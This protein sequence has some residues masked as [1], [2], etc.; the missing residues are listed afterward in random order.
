MQINLRFKQDNSSLILVTDRNDPDTSVDIEMIG[1]EN[2][3]MAFSR[4]VD[5]GLYGHYGH[6]FDPDNTTNLDLQSAIKGLKFF[7]VT[8]IAPQIKA[9]R[10]PKSAHP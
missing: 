5:R 1:N 7:K 8:A 4:E 6:I 2:A 10:L 9:N 3:R